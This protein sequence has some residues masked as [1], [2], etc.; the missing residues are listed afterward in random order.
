MSKELRTEHAKRL[1]S[2]KLFQES[3][4]VLKEQLMNEWQH[5][6]HLDVE[7]RESLWLAVK[8]TD[9]LKAHFESIVET[10]K[11]SE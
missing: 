6:Q 8:L 7:R 3:W 10:G 2:D 5:S 11:M 9:R 4:G 1:T